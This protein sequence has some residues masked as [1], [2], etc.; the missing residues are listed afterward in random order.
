MPAA[1]NLVDCLDA[2]SCDALQEMFPGSPKTFYAPAEAEKY[3][4]KR[5]SENVANASGANVRAP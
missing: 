5:L 4:K 2:A 1:S 3:Y